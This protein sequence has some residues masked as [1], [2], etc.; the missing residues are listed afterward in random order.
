MGIFFLLWLRGFYN[1]ESELKAQS[2][3]LGIQPAPKVRY[4]HLIIAY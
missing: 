3:I 1:K 2:I 4:V